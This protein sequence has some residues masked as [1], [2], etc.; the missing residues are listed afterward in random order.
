MSPT[1]PTL[2]AAEPSEYANLQFRTDHSGNEIAIRPNQF[3][4]S[5]AQ[6]QERFREVLAEAFAV[7]VGPNI[8]DQDLAGQIA[9]LR[10]ALAAR[11]D[12][13][14]NWV[15]RRNTFLNSVLEEPVSVGEVHLRYTI[16]TDH[17]VDIVRLVREL[18]ARGVPAQPNHVYFC[19]S[20]ERS[21]F[22]ADDSNFFSPNLIA[23]K[24]FNPNL[25][26][27]YGFNPNLIASL[28]GGGG[29]GCGGRLSTSGSLRVPKLGA[30][31]AAPPT[32]WIDP[33]TLVNPPPDNVAVHIIDVMSPTPDSRDDNQYTGELTAGTAGNGV[34]ENGDGWTD[35]ATGHG[36]FVESLVYLHS[37]IEANLWQA[38]DPLGV[39]DDEHLVNA[40]QRVD[41]SVD[42]PEERKVLNLSLGG[43]NI[44]NRPGLALATQ[45]EEMIKRNW[46]IVASAGNN[47]SCRL[48]WPAALPGVVAVGA[49]GPCGPAWFSNFGAWVD[50]SAPGVDVVARY[51]KLV[52]LTE[53]GGT[54]VSDDEEA[55][56][57]D[58]D[59]SR[60]LRAADFSGEWAEW[61]G[62]SFS[63]P[64]VTAK[65]A[66]ALGAVDPATE[67]GEANKQA[68]EAVL[69]GAEDFIPGYGKIIKDGP[70]WPYT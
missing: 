46:L 29:C 28:T 19:T 64:V 39:I 8:G 18:E 69:D 23:G 12:D 54:I 1:E 3:L 53:L 55:M 67:T 32:D 35:P 50:V 10:Q 60:I 13:P 7:T 22:A 24:N 33:T 42:D 48:T 25:I 62:T 34:D 36:D 52:E 51:P 58:T 38:A 44:D 40:L 45:I 6:D 15:E 4:T 21:V 31:P 11:E 16:D 57:P 30:R 17:E 47:A 27:G 2:P 66:I 41:G 61:S 20:T 63:A 5:S 37:G 59:G 49:V 26:A 9:A 43:Y 70:L 65:L 68:I 14:G 56:T